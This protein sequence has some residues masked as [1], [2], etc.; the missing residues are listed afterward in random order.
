MPLSLWSRLCVCYAFP[1]DAEQSSGLEAPAAACALPG[2]D[3]EVPAYVEPTAVVTTSAVVTG[4]CDTL[5]DEPARS[6]RVDAD[7][8]VD[9]SML[10]EPEPEAC[11]LVLDADALLCQRYLAY[12]AVRP[13]S[14]ESRFALGPNQLLDEHLRCV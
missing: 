14:A 5:R 7:A 10:T 8:S 3:R 2:N 12:T 11:A 6:L 4:P 13:A 9:K 1:K